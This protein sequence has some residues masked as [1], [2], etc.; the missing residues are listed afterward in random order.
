MALVKG[1]K[2]LECLQSPGQLQRLCQ[3]AWAAQYNTWLLIKLTLKGVVF[4]FPLCS[5]AA[6]VCRQLWQL[7]QSVKQHFSSSSAEAPVAAVESGHDSGQEAQLMEW[8]AADTVRMLQERNGAD[9]L[10]ECASPQS[11]QESLSVEC[12]A[13][14]QQLH[15]SSQGCNSIQVE[16]QPATASLV[17]CC[18]GSSED[19]GASPDVHQTSAKPASD[20]L[21]RTQHT[22]AIL[23]AVKQK[24]DALRQRVCPSFGHPLV[25]VVSLCH[26]VDVRPDHSCWS[27]ADCGVDSVSC[28]DRI[29]SAHGF[30]QAN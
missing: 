2:H 25:Q 26:M 29:C 24:P 14:Q 9:A 6:C 19:N 21:Q 27:H 4:S 5:Y 22:G 11:Q 18:G 13:P 20:A 23:P 28:R 1:P 12:A 30:C 3:T 16:D 17:T 15:T 7:F 10:Q 8:I